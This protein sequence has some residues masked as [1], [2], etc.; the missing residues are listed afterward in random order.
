MLVKW[1]WIAYTSP[2]SIP[3]DSFLT[4]PP[5]I[6]YVFG[7]QKVADA[8]MNT[9]SSLDKFEQGVKDCLEAWQ[10]RSSSR[11]RAFRL[12]SRSYRYF[13]LSEIVFTWFFFLSA[14]FLL[15]LFM[16]FFVKSLIEA[17]YLY[18]SISQLEQ[19]SLV[20]R[21]S[22]VFCLLFCI[23]CGIHVQGQEALSLSLSVA[24]EDK[25]PMLSIDL[26]TCTSI[27]WYG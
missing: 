25:P 19:I 26:L 10:F 2:F 11:I 9:I 1:S 13:S 16:V 3:P 18:H 23:S 21:S 7:R 12:W 27:D 5:I 24:G 20:M 4:R 6:P 22:L 14:W 8:L 17:R 15:P